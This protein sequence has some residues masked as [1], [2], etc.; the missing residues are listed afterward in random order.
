MLIDE[1]RL[2][3]NGHEILLRSA[4]AEDAQMLIDY[5]RTVCGETRFL[6]KE[7]DEVNLTV[8]QEI[9]FIEGHNRAPDGLL[10]IAFL[11]GEY[12]GNCSFD[13]KAGSKRNAHRAGLGIALYQKYTGY[14][15]GRILM[16][17]M[18]KYA[19]KLGYEQMEL[20]VVQG[21]ERAIGL[22]KSAG[23]EECGRIPNANKYDD[24]TYADDI[25]MVK[26]L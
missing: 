13:S 6:M 1:E 11:D 18:I 14:G 21:N 23:F 22:Y 26:K 3:L 8:E 7:A 10:I 12:A 20:T 19:K 24:G 25:F 9:N 16:E 17:K 15:L 4:T 5:L 2:T